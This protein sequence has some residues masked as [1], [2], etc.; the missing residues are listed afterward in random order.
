MR[1]WRNWQTHQTQ[2]L[3][4][5]TA[6]GFESHQAQQETLDFS[7]VFLF[8]KLKAINKAIKHLFLYIYL[9]K[10]F[11]EKGGSFGDVAFFDEINSNFVV[12]KKIIFVINHNEK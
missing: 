12:S 7:R 11:G 10:V 2:N 4:L 1:L 3:T 5:V 8:S 6:C 9:L